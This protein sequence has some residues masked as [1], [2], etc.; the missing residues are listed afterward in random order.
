MPSVTGTPL[1]RTRQL[2]VA[3]H[4][5]PTWLRLDMSRYATLR[6]SADA[7]DDAPRLRPPDRQQTGADGPRSP[8]R[9]LSK[10]LS[11]ERSPVP[12]LA[13]YSQFTA[14][15]LD[16]ILQP[17]PRPTTFLPAAFPHRSLLTVGFVLGPADE[18]PEVLRRQ[19]DPVSETFA[20]PDQRRGPLLPGKL[21][22]PIN[23]GIFDFDSSVRILFTSL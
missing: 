5:N 14:A 13:R 6:K 15:S 2:S 9:S 19:S 17:F 18:E 22:T 11:S 20:R 3:Q 12:H 16:A 8:R 21:A 4:A 23:L 1:T 10:L 7:F